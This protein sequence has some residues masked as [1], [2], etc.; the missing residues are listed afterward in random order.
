MTELAFEQPAPA[1][2]QYDANALAGYSPY[3]MDASSYAPMNAQSFAPEAQALP[4]GFPNPEIDF[5]NGGGGGLPAG[6]ET[7]PQAGADVSPP[8]SFAPT[9]NAS[10]ALPAE[11]LTPEQQAAQQQMGV[12]LE[13]F[14]TLVRDTYSDQIPAESRKNP[15]P[16]E[17]GAQLESVLATAE[18]AGRLEALT[19]GQAIKDGQTQTHNEPFTPPVQQ[20]PAIGGPTEPN[21]VM[22]MQM[23][24]EAGMGMPAAMPAEVPPET[25]MAAPQQAMPLS[26]PQPASGG[27]TDTAAMGG[28]PAAAMGGDPSAALVGDPSAA[29]PESQPDTMQF[30]NSDVSQSPENL[31]AQIAAAPEQHLQ[32]AK[33][34][35]LQMLE[36]KR[37][38]TMTK[39]DLQAFAQLLSICVSA[40]YE[41]GRK[42]RAAGPAGSAEQTPPTEMPADPSIAL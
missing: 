36:A 33:G 39:E 7:M 13:S 32:A 10:L 1:Q 34:Q 2:Q 27:M 23:A 40:S 29:M 30:T 25:A 9:E 31:Q 14:M 5:A 3:Q 16:E 24:P 22:P 28:D 35:L 6:V 19:P 4:T 18:Q 26:T 42:G 38:Q 20:I 15:T 37:G 17:F 12:A 8:Q 21:T 41:I 11:Q